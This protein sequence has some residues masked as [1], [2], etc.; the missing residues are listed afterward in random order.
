MVNFIIIDFIIVVSIDCGLLNQNDLLFYS[1]EFNLKSIS[2]Y[3]KFFIK[4]R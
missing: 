3:L 4:N 2:M 1:K